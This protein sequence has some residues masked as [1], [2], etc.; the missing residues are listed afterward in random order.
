MTQKLTN[1]AF[2]STLRASG[3]LLAAL[4]VLPL[5]AAANM[6]PVFSSG[7][8]GS[9]A[10]L[11]VGA[12]D[13]H[14]TITSSPCGATAATA[15]TP[16]TTYAHNT[17][18]SQWITS[19][20]QFDVGDFLYETTFSLSGLDLSTVKLTGSWATD[21][22]G[23]ISLNGSNLGITL[24]AAAF[25]SLTPFSISS[26]FV[27]GVN[28]LVFDVHNDGSLSGLQVNLAGTASPVGTSSTPESPSLILLAM[29]LLGLGWAV[30][31]QNKRGQT[32]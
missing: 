17:L 22:E 29:G 28:T 5:S 1:I 7:V 15:E 6:A 2:S 27:S 26:G 9:G 32:I 21:N 31:R 30:H 19:S 25:G 23:S 3:I 20:C 10:L 11:A 8:D 18:T 12:T 4:L 14:Y 24:P 13:S 16:F